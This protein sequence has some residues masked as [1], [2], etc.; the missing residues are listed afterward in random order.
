LFAGWPN[1]A[2]EWLYGWRPGFVPRFEPLNVLIAI[3]A[4][5]A[6][7]ALVRWSKVFDDRLTFNWAATV[8]LA[9]VLFMTLW[10]SWIDFGNSYRSVVEE[11]KTRLP[12]NT[13][14][15]ASRDL[16][17]PQRAMLDYFG[18][19]LT[20]REPASATKDCKV[21]LVEGTTR[22]EELE[23]PWRWTLLWSG[24]RPGDAKERF[25]LLSRH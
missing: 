25:W 10:V 5:A 4:S 14:C 11:I 16:G 24:T 13:N 22:P 1:A 23:S 2:S 21:L 12:A 6:W 7:L 15:I 8:T 19:I 3:F 20:R 17:E 18:G 9:W